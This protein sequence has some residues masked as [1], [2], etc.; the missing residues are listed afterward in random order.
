M[1]FDRDTDNVVLGPRSTC[2]GG[3]SQM[4]TITATVKTGPMSMRALAYVT[5]QDLDRF[6]YSSVAA[7]K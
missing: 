3:V 4:L 7:A 6:F 5:A 1:T 2:I